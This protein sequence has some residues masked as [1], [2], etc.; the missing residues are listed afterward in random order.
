LIWFAFPAFPLALWSAHL[1]GRGFI[2]GPK[3][4]SFRYLIAIILVSFC[5]LVLAPNARTTEIM[6]LLI[7]LSLLVIPG[8][9]HLKRG[10]SGFLDWLGIVFFGGGILLAWLVWS[11]LYLGAP[12]GFLLKQLNQFQP[13]FA[14][15]VRT[16]P[17]LCAAVLTVVWFAMIRPARRTHKRALVNWT[18][19]VTALWG[20]F[21][22]LLMPYLDFGKSYRKPV[23]ALVA[24]LPP[25]VRNGQQC[26]VSIHLGASQRAMFDYVGQLYPR[27]TD[28][29]DPPV[30]DWVIE[31][32]SVTRG[33]SASVP[34]AQF[35][36]VG[37]FARPGDKSEPWLLW[38]RK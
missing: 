4:F 35:E 13:G 29:S 36:R 21:T 15:P 18:V 24:Q 6:P 17:V 22:L 31:Q 19:G 32:R 3:Q 20:V 14:E 34:T 5:V 38:R 33:N 1:I 25:E 16:L 8:L 9:D 27:T 11:T 2:G 7:P 10:Q 23:E 26:I 30:C 28:P 12:R 37:T